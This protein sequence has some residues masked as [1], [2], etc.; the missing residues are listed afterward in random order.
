[1]PTALRRPA[2]RSMR[3]RSSWTTLP[4]GVSAQRGRIRRSNVTWQR[5]PRR[6]L[7]PALRRDPLRRPIGDGLT[8]P[9]RVDPVAAGHVGDN[10]GAELVCVP[11]EAERLLAAGAS[12]IAGS[13]RRRP[14]RPW[15]G[16]S[17]RSPSHDT[18]RRATH[19]NYKR[20]QWHKT[21]KNPFYRVGYSC[22]GLCRLGD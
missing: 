9:T 17:S 4:I 12:Q 13:A 5:F 14:R 2:L 18:T 11:L 20:R 21:A 6:W 7:E 3:R 10:G 8:R 1:M 19:D 16:A 15:S 22:D